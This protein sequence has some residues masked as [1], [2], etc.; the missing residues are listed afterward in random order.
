MERALSS[1]NFKVAEKAGL[2]VPGSPGVYRRISATKDVLIED[3]TAVRLRHE[4]ASR[5]STR[6][7]SRRSLGI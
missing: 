1:S 7:I 5:K 6:A 2:P 3:T 4:S